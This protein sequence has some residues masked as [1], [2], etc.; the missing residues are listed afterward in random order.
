[1]ASHDLSVHW[2]TSCAQLVDNMF[3]KPF[4]MFV[5]QESP[6][7]QPSGKIC[8]NKKGNFNN[9]TTISNSFNGNCP[10]LI[11]FMSLLTLMRFF[12]ILVFLLR[13]K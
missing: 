12:L 11:S 10:L 1:M 7:K 6:Q 9:L 3:L 2:R 8:A 13:K 4:F 5:T